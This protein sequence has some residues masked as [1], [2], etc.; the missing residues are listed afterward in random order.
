MVSI[1]QMV[2]RRAHDPEVVGSNPTADILC[3]INVFI[4]KIKIFSV[5]YLLRFNYNNDNRGS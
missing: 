4:N 1:E 2:A 3:T 5:R